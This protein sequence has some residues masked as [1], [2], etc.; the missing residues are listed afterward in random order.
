MKMI[1]VSV[2]APANCVLVEDYPEY[3]NP[4]KNNT[5]QMTIKRMI[6]EI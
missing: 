4:D 5:G 1:D 6:P 3:T 2:Q